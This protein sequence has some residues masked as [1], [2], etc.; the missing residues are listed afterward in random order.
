MN[1]QKTKLMS[2]FRERFRSEKIPSY[3]NGILHLLINLS[4]LLLMIIGSFYKIQNFTWPSFLKYFLIVYVCGNLVIFLIH[5]YLLHRIVPGFKFAY[6]IH[7]KWHHTFF[8]NEFSVPDK[9][10]DFFILFFPI[11]V[12]LGFGLGFMPAA[13]FG[14]GQVLGIDAALYIMGFSALYFLSYEIVHFSS[15]LPK[16]HFVLKLPLFKF[17]YKHHLDHHN[18]KLMHNYN[19]NIVYPLFDFVFCNNFQNK[20]IIQ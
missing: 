15:H 14:L 1:D 19:F 4:L 5:K 3:Y 2:E 12:V 7:S 17:M 10:Q 11:S 16:T 13:Y 8:T 6:K 9:T 20:K 18:P